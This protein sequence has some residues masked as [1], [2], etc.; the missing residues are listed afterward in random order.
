MKYASA[1]LLE[2][3]GGGGVL[4]GFTADLYIGGVRKIASL[5]IMDPSFSW[6]GN[7]KIQG[8]GSCRVVWSSDFAESLSPT[9][10]SDDLAPFGP[11]LYVSVTVTVGL[12]SETVPLGWF[13]ITDV[14][15]ARDE[16]GMFRGRSIVIGSIV[17]L[18]L[19][20]RFM[21]LDV[22]P[23]DVPT[24]ARYLQS[25]WDEAARITEFQVTES[26]A[27]APIPRKVVHSE[28]RLDAVYDLFN[29]VD[30]VPYM[31]DD[32][33]LSARPN[34]WPEPVGTLRYGEGGT[35]ISVG[36][37]LSAAG[38]HNRV[39]VRGESNDNQRILAVA[40]VR[41]G[42]LRVR[43][44]DG[45][46]SPFRPRTRFISSQY[47]TTYVQAKAW[48][49]RELKKSAQVGVRT[50]PVV[51]LFNPL[52]E[53]GDVY[54]LETPGR[55]ELARVIDIELSEGGETPMKLEVTDG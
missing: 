5:P 26:V 15:S 52:R 50:V 21:L 38:V 2:M 46:P 41:D 36:R 51:E 3:L 17:E 54:W 34:E 4:C 27:D 16:Y 44:A 9:G 11:E 48:A 39:A 31:T 22:N 29:V 55:R 6:S 1:N 7:A 28:N 8:S 18:E 10:I 20:D 37:G 14:P 32:G 33:T 45:T 35:L 24:P 53:V 25:V 47:V 23:F 12:L 40:E 13:P 43:N 19:Q 42:P 30:A 49:D